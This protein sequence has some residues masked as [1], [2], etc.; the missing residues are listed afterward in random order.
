MSSFTRYPRNTGGFSLD[1]AAR[2]IQNSLSDLP[3]LCPT[4]AA[5]LRRV[6]G[7]EHSERVW[8]LRCTECGRGMVYRNPNVQPRRQ[9]PSS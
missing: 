9:P 3:A 7:E 8:I 5:P 1:E 4:C 6:V 2:A